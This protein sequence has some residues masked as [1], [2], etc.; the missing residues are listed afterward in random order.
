[1]DI[2]NINGSIVLSKSIMEGS[3]SV[4]LSNLQPGLYFVVIED[5]NG[6]TSVEK[7]LKK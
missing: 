3:T 7:L 2:I 5:E 1:M 6:N 4:D